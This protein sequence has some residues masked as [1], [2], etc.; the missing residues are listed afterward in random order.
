VRAIRLHVGDARIELPDRE[1]TVQKETPPGRQAPSRQ[2]SGDPFEDL[3]SRAFPERR[4][5]PRQA[6]TPKLFLRAELSDPEPYV[7]EQT[8]YTLWLYTQSDIGA[9]QPT[10]VPD[11]RGFWVRE[12]AQPAELKPEW[13]QERGERYGRVP[14]LRRALFPLKPGE[15]TLEP[16]EADI[17][18]TVADFGPFGSPFGRNESFHL[19]SDPV[20]VRARALPPP[21][22][23]EN[24]QGPVG[25]IALSARLDRNQLD[26][27]QAAT[28]NVRCTGRGNLQ[29]LSPPVLQLPDGL[30]GYPPR[31][32]MVERQSDGALVSSAEW[33]YVLVPDAGGEFEIAGLEIPYFDPRKQEYGRA[34][35]PP[36]EL[37]V[38]GPAA[39]APGH[40]AAIA[41]AGATPRDGA[42]SSGG[43]GAAPTDGARRDWAEM[44]RRGALP[45]GA[46]GFALLGFWWF[47]R[48][49]TGS[50]DGRILAAAIAGAAS[51]PTPRQSAASLEEA[52]RQHLQ[53]RFE[54]PPSTP[55]SA[56][57]DRLVAQGADPSAA[58]SL[59]D[60]A[61]ELHYLRY[62]PELAAADQLLSHA[63]DSS[64]RLARRL[65]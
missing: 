17:V 55:V 19:K 39:I 34:T 45:A 11:F 36:L 30:R 56:W 48:A 60:L 10:K 43:E 57:S 2:R 16:L 59:A 65:R 64:R 27:G 3:F 58:K 25:E 42:G 35:T 31:Q 9:F 4:T 54:I 7:G 63:L 20:R 52:W 61:H 62:A 38:R 6:A 46:I 15:T 53:R 12:I 28:L 22:G 24:F 14:M 47:R 41:D 23:G 5:V 18:A 40:E 51:E 13:V 49:S 21:Q 29:S 50:A 33:S 1:A 26:A 8:V 44:A 37:A 32:S